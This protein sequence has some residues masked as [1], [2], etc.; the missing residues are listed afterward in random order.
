VLMSMATHWKARQ[1]ERV[2]IPFPPEFPSCPRSALCGRAESPRFAVGGGWLLLSQL[3]PVRHLF[4]DLI[5][6]STQSVV[7]FAFKSEEFLQNL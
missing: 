2:I 1:Q 5:C 6:L 3:L 7:V 4:E